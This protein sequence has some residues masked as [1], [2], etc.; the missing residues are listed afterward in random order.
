MPSPR[1]RTDCITCGRKRDT[2]YFSHTSEECYACAA[3][4][5]QTRLE[6][7]TKERRMQK[8]ISAQRKRI[9]AARKA[10]KDPKAELAAR[11]AAER[12]AAKLEARRIEEAKSLALKAEK[13]ESALKRE[14]AARV[15]ARKYLLPFVVRMKPDYQ[16][17]W[18]HKD[19]ARRLEKFSREVAE[20][21]SPRLMIQMPPR[22][23][24]S[25]LASA[26]FPAWH[27]GQYPNHEIIQA[28][29]ASSLAMDFSRKV[30]QSLRED[31]YRVL[32]A[33]TALD[34]DNQNAE[35]WRTTKGG[36][37]MPAGVGGPITGKGAHCLPLW[38]EVLTPEGPRT[39][40]SLM[41]SSE[42][43]QRVLSYEGDKIVARKINAFITRTANHYYRLQTSTGTLEATGEHPVCVGF[44]EARPVFRRVDEL[45]VGDRVIAVIGAV[46]ARPEAVRNVS[47]VSGG[48]H[49]A[50]HEVSRC[51]R[52]LRKS[53]AY[54]LEQLRRSAPS[55]WDF[56]RA[57][58]R[59]VR[60]GVSRVAVVGGAQAR[61]GAGIVLLLRNLLRRAPE[62]DVCGGGAPPVQ[63]GADRVPGVWD[64]V[65]AE[66]LGGGAAGV[67][68]LQQGVLRGY[69]AWRP[70]ESGARFPWAT[71]LP[72]RVSEAAGDAPASAVRGLWGAGVGAA[73][74][75]WG[76]GEQRSGEPGTGLSELPHEASS[77]GYTVIGAIERID[78]D[79]VVGDLE[80]EGTHSFL[81]PSGH[82][83]LNC[84]IIDD[85]VK[86]R[87]EAESALTRQAIK[88]WYSSTAYTR[89]APGGGVLIIQTRWHMDDLSGWLEEMMRLGQGDTWEIVRYPAIATADEPYRKKGEALHPERYPL[90]ALQRIQRV[91]FPRDWA[92]LYQ[93]TPTAEEG[94]YFKREFLQWY[95]GQAPK[96]LRVFSAWDLAIGKKEQNDWTVGAVAGVDEEDNLYL[97]DMYRGRWDS[98]EIV[99]KMLECYRKWQPELIGIEKGQISMAIG[100]H[101]ER[102]IREERLYAMA[103][104]ELPPGRQD[105]VAR[106]RSIQG[107]MHQGR[108]Y[109]P[110]D[111][112][113]VTDLVSEMLQFPNGVHD[114]QVDSLAWI[115]IML[116]TMPPPMA[117]KEP[118]RKSWKDKLKA[119]IRGGKG[120]H[121]LSA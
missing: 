69:V 112:A 19:I 84:L 6:E 39:I 58:L 55:A 94:E 37:Y 59:G 5:K 50:D 86:N 14:L 4:H 67:A 96:R 117:L 103:T 40:E 51:R 79:V 12:E 52:S 70:Y 108:V 80:V 10:R 89:L 61:E 31:K 33:N 105:K 64:G 56:G 8:E 102:R 106:A 100:P 7:Q 41:K 62:Q 17:G 49:Q 95:S 68:L 116:Q 66:S 54:L 71:I 3:K 92:A 101:L 28:S 18:V 98:F 90:E 119:H 97:L 9:Q 81:V 44:R 99:E 2:R 20:G 88:D 57:L 11:R 104:K 25:E 35:G 60:Q 34:A 78:G 16:V 30:R 107:R 111:A 113:W 93:Q 115:G 15:L 46:T 36:G 120:K 72:P 38:A 53:V 13:E 32:F 74:S 73:P 48:V 121:F 23:G 45:R 118:V 76:Q 42:E 65:R 85:P 47:N 26:H 82:L 114:D 83:L 21:K 27:L 1:L 29:Y 91:T 77:Y 24:K 63:L 109:M 87:E 75:G 43:A 110:K 22:H